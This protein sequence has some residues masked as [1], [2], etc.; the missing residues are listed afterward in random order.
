MASPLS[1]RV[2]ASAVMVLGCAAPA[3]ATIDSCA[4][5][6]RT[7]D[8][9]LNLRIGPGAGFEAVLKLFPGDQLWVDTATCETRRGIAAC[10]PTGTWWHVVSVRRLDAGTKSYT[11]GWAHRRF[12]APT[13]CPGD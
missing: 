7:P 2:I 13:P 4:E 12:L 3:R 9:F 6:R 11:R 1:H 5:V 8:G 10:D